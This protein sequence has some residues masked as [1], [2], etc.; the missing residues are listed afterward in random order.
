MDDSGQA[1]WRERWRLQLLGV[2]GIGLVALWAL[3]IAHGV[4]SVY[5]A[6]TI[7]TVAVLVELRRARAQQSGDV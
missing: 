6:A 3:A 1:S 7:W 4:L 2:Q 5:L